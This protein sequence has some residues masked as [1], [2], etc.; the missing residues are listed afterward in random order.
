VGLPHGLRTL[1]PFLPSMPI[2]SLDMKISRQ[3]LKKKAFF[4]QYWD[5]YRLGFEFPMQG[6]LSVGDD[7]A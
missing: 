5:N 2:L 1:L 4:P 7:L 6:H 3:N